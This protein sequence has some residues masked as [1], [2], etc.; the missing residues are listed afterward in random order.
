MARI[1]TDAAAARPPDLMQGTGLF[2]AALSAQ[3]GITDW[4]H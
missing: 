4:H 1:A 3:I 2:P